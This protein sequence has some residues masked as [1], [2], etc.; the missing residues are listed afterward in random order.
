MDCT[1]KSFWEEYIHLYECLEA[2]VNEE[3]WT[4]KSQMGKIYVPYYI[5]VSQ[6]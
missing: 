6:N 4:F 5:L 2:L 1:I 3:L